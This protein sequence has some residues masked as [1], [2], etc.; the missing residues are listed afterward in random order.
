MLLMV[1]IVCI[2]TLARTGAFSIF[3][4][5]LA[6][7]YQ[8]E[9]LII[10]LK[11]VALEEEFQSLFD[12]NVSWGDDKYRFIIPGSKMFL[13]DLRTSHSFVSIHALEQILNMILNYRNSL[14][15]KIHV[16]RI[17]SCLYY[18]WFWLKLKI[19][20]TTL[21]TPLNF[22][23]SFAILFKGKQFLCLVVTRKKS[24]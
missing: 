21:S 10:L 4:E 22:L 15:Q 19:L 7:F 23:F 20:K 6:S 16:F 11:F 18:K 1:S 5:F 9:H 2:I 3:N 17:Q 12:I 13:S 24:P 8:S 14:H